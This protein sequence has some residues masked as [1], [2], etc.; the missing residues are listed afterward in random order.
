[1]ADTPGSLLER[2]QKQP[3]AAS[4]QRLVDLYTPLIRTWLCRYETLP[5]DVED[6]LQDVLHVLVRELPGFRHQQRRGAFRCWL[7][8]ITV[9]RLR[10]HWREQRSRRR[11]VGFEAILDQL[12]DPASDLSQLWDQEHDR[13]VACQL[14]ERI[15]R[16]FTPG[17]WQAFR[18]YVLEGAR[19]AEVSR[20]TGLSVNAVLLARSRILR[21]LREEARGLLD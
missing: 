18:R 15:C 19:A 2:L 4:W 12:E 11:E 20:E 9:N 21:R 10:Q 14:L 3:D 17:T 6:L 8:M 1:M 16:D 5:D 7:R 13:H